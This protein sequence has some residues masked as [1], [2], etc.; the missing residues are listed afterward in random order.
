MKT[1]KTKDLHKKGTLFKP[2]KKTTKLSR[3]SIIDMLT[4]SKKPVLLIIEDEKVEVPTTAK[5]LLLKILRGE[6]QSSQE[7]EKI[8]TSQ[9]LADMLNVSRPYAIKL[10]ESEQ[11]PSYKV[12][13]HR[14]VTEADAILFK[15]K[16]KS[17]KLK[18][19]NE[20]SNEHEELEIEYK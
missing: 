10:I 12:G 3:E 8:L 15:A 5:S 2:K 4:K 13:T 1:L 18:A 9:Q 19:L 17:E 14:R 7:K 20:L 6:L 16:M 11:I